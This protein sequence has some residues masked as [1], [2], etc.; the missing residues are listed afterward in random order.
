M[1]KRA[2]GWMGT[3]VW[4]RTRQ[5]GQSADRQAHAD[6]PK[7]QAGTCAPGLK[8]QKVT[9]LLPPR[10]EYEPPPIPSRTPAQQSSKLRVRAAP[11]FPEGQARAGHFTLFF[12]IWATRYSFLLW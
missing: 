10:K 8:C 9:R 12:C 7:P 11:G 1:S 4:L 5:D 3:T 6:A 2:T